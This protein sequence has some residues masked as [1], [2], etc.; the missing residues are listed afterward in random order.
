MLKNTMFYILVFCSIGL[1]WSACTSDEGNAATDEMEEAV[2]EKTPAT[3]DVL[4][5][6]NLV[7]TGEVQSQNMARTIRSTGTIT[8]PPTA[9]QSVHP[10]IGGQLRFLKYLPGD[11]VKKG[12]VLAIVENPTLIE[13]QR[14]LLETK[15]NLDFARKDFERKK[16]LKAGNATPEKTFDESQNQYELLTATY[17][18]LAEELR[19]FGID[20]AALEQQNNYQSSIQ[21]Y[22]KSAGF[23]QEVL[24]NQGQMVTP[25]TRLM[26]IANKDAMYLSLNVLSKD[27]NWVEKGQ[28]VHFTLPNSSKTFQ[29]K[30]VKINPT[31]A[32]G[33]SNLSVHCQILNSDKSE[34]IPG[35]FADAK[36]A[37][38]AT[39]IKG[40]PRTAV[41]KEGE[42]YFGFKVNEHAVEKIEL[43]GVEELGG[44]LVFEN[45]TDGTWVVEGAYYLE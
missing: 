36:I 30:V 23:V 3:L 31:L 44:V 8:I 7:K 41:V 43:T 20:V 11:Y 19:L 15:A 2:L 32:P 25:E 17:N 29:A 4:L 45:D 34:L 5:K 27:V 9:I 12:T 21:I 10:K 35:L 13:K 38:D 6:N 33:A 28:T 1:W 42:K 24:V 40:L 22:A 37:L 16:I 18:G 14:Q 26:D 39:I